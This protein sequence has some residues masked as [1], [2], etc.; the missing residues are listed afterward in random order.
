MLEITVERRGR[1]LPSS[2]CLN[3]VVISA[4]GIAKIIR[5]H[6]ESDLRLPG[7]SPG[8]VSWEALP[9]RF[10]LGHYRSDGLII[11][12]PTG[13]T[14]YSAAAGGPILDQELEA[15]ILN[16]ICPFALSNR[17][18]VLP[19]REKVVVEVEA[20]QRSGVL[21]TLDGQETKPLEP[22]DRIHIAPAPYHA[23]LIASDRRGF[24][25]ALRGKLNWF[26]G[27]DA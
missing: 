11:A 8:E 19:S 4:S 1:V 24:Y 26:G 20:E 3:D 22:A 23:E 10:S 2:A 9:E 16:P 6:A 7:V 14:A 18:V 25:Q 13:S 27:P 21:L 17:P 5:L 15:I 12:T